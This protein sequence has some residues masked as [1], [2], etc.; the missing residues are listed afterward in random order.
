MGMQATSREDICQCSDMFCQ[1]VQRK[2]VI[3][4]EENGITEPSLGA[5]QD[6]S[7]D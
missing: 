4:S 2:D 6:E 5:T 3:K 1:E 7:M